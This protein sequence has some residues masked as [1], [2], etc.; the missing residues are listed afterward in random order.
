MDNARTS[1]C[2]FSVEELDREL[3]VR[4]AQDPDEKRFKFSDNMEPHQRDIMEK[5]KELYDAAKSWSRNEA[6]R[7]ISTEELVKILLFKTGR[8]EINGNKGV[9]GKDDRKDF[10]EI[11]DDQVKQNAARVAAVFNSDNLIATNRKSAM[12]KVQNYGKTF[13]LSDNEIF[14]HQF[15]AT[16]R[17][18]T[19]FLVGEDVIATAGHCACKSTVTDLRIVFDYKMENSDTPVIRIPDDHIYKGVE[20]IHRVRIPEYNKPDWALVKLDR[21]VEGR[22]AVTLSEEIACGQPVYVI[23]HPCGL[24]LKYA[25]GAKILS[26]SKACF[27]ADLDI[28]M[29]NS[30]SPVFNSDTHEVIGIVVRGDNRDFRWTGKDWVSVIYS[31]RKTYPRSPECTR[32]SE[33]IE[34]CRT[35]GGM[36]KISHG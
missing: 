25:P 3:I 17:V 27:S 28:Y 24:P 30:G 15:I 7:D 32:A 1:P 20:I 4:G 21:K 9:W 29:G 14:Q 33:F 34:H 2:E 19:G 13:N 11:E 10:Y 35:K 23:G 8:T 16:G 31:N 22:T 5:V 36:K 18:C 6:L 26:I 12:L